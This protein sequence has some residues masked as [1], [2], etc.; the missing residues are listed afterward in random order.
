MRKIVIYPD[1][2]LRVK[3]EEIKVVDEALLKDIADL[4]EVLQNESRHA[5]G[6]AAVQIGLNRRFFGL[7]AGEKK[8]PVVFINPK[9][10]KYIGEKTKPM[11]VFADG[12]QEAFLEGC[13]SFPNLFGVIRRHLTIEAS[14]QE[15]EGNQLVAKS[16]KFKGIEAIAFQHESEHL[17]GILFTDHIKAQGGEFYRWE[18]EK[19][20]KWSVDKVIDLE[21]K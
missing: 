6:L 15:I 18:G 19:K 9:V 17:D 14:W 21:K 20:I 3:T 10:T 5:A 11:M 1:P 8:D 7:L 16:G 12:K 2:I 4:M 13:L